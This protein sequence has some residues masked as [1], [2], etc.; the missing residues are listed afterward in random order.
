MRALMK[1]PS[2]DVLH[3][4]MNVNFF[5]TVYWTKLAV[6]KFIRAKGII[7]GVTPMQVIPGS[8]PKP[9]FTT[10]F[11]YKGGGNPQTG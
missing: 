4:G 11:A 2:T 6:K 8:R 1:D 9:V 7:V 3:K 5:G 10:K